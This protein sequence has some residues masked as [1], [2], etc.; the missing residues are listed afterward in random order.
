MSGLKFVRDE[1]LKGMYE[2]CEVIESA[3]GCERCPLRDCCLDVSSF[4]SICECVSASM[5][6][7]FLG[8]ADD[9]EEHNN[10]DD[11]FSYYADVKR[12]ADIEEH[13]IYER[14]GY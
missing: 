5:V 6:D 4:K 7:E 12:K 13:S 2:A 9:I 11:M 8:F 1:N 10:E 3:G 14:W